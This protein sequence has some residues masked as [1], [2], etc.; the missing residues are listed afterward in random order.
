[1][2]PYLDWFFIAAAARLGWYAAEM[3]IEQ[4]EHQ[5]TKLFAKKDEYK[6]EPSRFRTI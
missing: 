6:Y 5:L 1:M 2:K 4:A 3:L